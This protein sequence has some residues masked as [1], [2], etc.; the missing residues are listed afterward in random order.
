MARWITCWLTADFALHDNYR[1]TQQAIS[2]TLAPE[3]I[4]WLKGRV[5]AAGL[6]SVSELLDQL[7]TSARQG[8]HI[9]QRCSVAATIQIDP[10]DPMLTSADHTIRTL[11][12]ESL[13][14]PLAVHERA[15]AYSAERTRTKKPRG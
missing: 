3:N 8:G 12:A 7:V 10:S 13:D 1:M 2:V 9:V 6:R 15:P 4:T 14:Q 5:G 11:F